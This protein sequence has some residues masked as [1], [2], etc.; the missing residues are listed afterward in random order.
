MSEKHFRQEQP[1]TYHIYEGKAPEYRAPK[2]ITFSGDLMAVENFLYTRPLNEEP[3]NVSNPGITKSLIVVNAENKTIVLHT[4]PTDPASGTITAAA[5]DNP[6]INE[7]GINSAITFTRE[8]L[9]KRLR[10]LSQLFPN[11]DEY[12]VLLSGLQRFVANTSG[13]VGADTDQRGNKDLQYQKKE[14]TGLPEVVTVYAA[15]IIGA[16]EQS[17]QVEVCLDVTDG[18]GAKFW[19]ESPELVA[20]QQQA[21][22]Q[23]SNLGLK[24]AQEKGFTIIYS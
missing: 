8:Q 4:N 14:Q 11:K 22:K 13:K 17:F 2:A 20:I 5:K 23:L 12:T 6:D 19:L 9:I 7:L 15:P 10:F 1:G 3:D 24:T 16:T 18:G 21:W